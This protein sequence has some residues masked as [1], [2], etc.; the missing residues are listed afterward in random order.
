MPIMIPA[1]WARPVNNVCPGMPGPYDH[2]YPITELQDMPCPSPNRVNVGRG[3]TY[4]YQ[5]RSSTVM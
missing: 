5:P 1:Y 4:K 3:P 2:D